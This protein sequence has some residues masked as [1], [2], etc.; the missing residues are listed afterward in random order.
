[1]S[2]ICCGTKA[3]RI[4]SYKPHH[5]PPWIL[6]LF[7]A[8]QHL[9]VQAS[10]LCACHSL[11]LQSRPLPPSDQISLL[12]SS[13]FACGIATGLQSSLGTRLPLVQSP[14]FELLIPAVILNRHS[15]AN[16]TEL[17]SGALLPL[18][19][20]LQ[21][22]PELQPTT[23]SG[24]LII[25]GVLQIL[26]GLSGLW[27]WI[28]RLCGPMVIAPTLSIIGLSCYK[29]AAQFC[30]SNWSISMSL[31][32]VIAFLS[33]TLRSLHF[34]VFTWN[35]KE[36]LKRRY[37]PVFR[38]LSMFLPISFIWIMSIY[39]DHQQMDFP[40]EIR[41]V[42]NTSLLTNRTRAW[43]WPKFSLET[44]GVGTAMALTSCIS[45]LGCYILCSRMLSC[46]PL[47]SHSCNRGICLEGFG[48]IIS[49]LLG[50][51][52]GVGSNIP[53]AGM[54]GITQ[55]G[56]R[57]SALLS[58]L[59]FIVLGCCPR[60][61]QMLM[62]IPFAVHGATLCLTF[63][64]AVGGGVSFFQYADIDSG[65]NIFIVG[66]T[67]FM[68][69]LVPRWLEARPTILDTGWPAADMFLLS[70]L[71]TPIF[72]GGV[73]SFI[74]DNTVEGTLEERGVHKSTLLWP[75][76]FSDPTR[77]GQE[78]EMAQA[79]GLPCTLSHLIPTMYPFNQLCPPPSESVAIAQGEEH[80]LLSIEATASDAEQGRV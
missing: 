23:V 13:L 49:G 75:F 2:M 20:Y 43:G 58:A 11:L 67:M 54:T 65:R 31:V 78:E 74:L 66:F 15:T 56:S 69:L 18:G 60:L 4:S 35:K 71:T 36:G 42:P 52:C 33:Q 80:K 77:R 30:S 76:T 40:S 47:P 19:L 27:K 14:T 79:Y 29:A 57:Q 16:R 22:T 3:S 12:A 55:V 50:S 44:L 53:T 51:V 34:P 9:L 37:A 73:F 28:L 39:W 48:N 8:L 46:P 72:L 1:M 62:S 10:L 45:S 5:T 64:M 17:A 38:M 24:A 21:L 32:V 68:A 63:S 61:S 41:L 26:S 7:F 25:A 59:L 6:S 70:L